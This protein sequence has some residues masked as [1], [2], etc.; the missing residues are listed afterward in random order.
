[1]LR[2]RRAPG[3]RRCSGR[4][5]L[6]AGAVTAAAALLASCA[7][8]TP[9]Q[10][11]VPFRG[12]LP[13]T[14]PGAAHAVGLPVSGRTRATLDVLT[15]TTTLTI[16]TASFGPGG[17]LLLVSTPAGQPAAQLSVTDRGAGPGDA[18]VDLRADNASAVTVTLSA[19]VGWLLELDGGTTRTDVD[20][21]GGYLTGIAFNAGSTV[22]RVALPRPLGTVPV[23]MTGGA[24]QFLLSLPAGVPARVTAGGGAGEVSLDGRSHTG[25]GGGSVFA[26][27]GW[28]AGGTGFDIDATAG[29]SSITVTR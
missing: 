12:P 7:T 29:A 18:L 17:S 10:L 26:T 16:G 1:V 4:R 20:L 11:G 15:G 25:V 8:A 27:P 21:R 22:I 2:F 23:R 19:D 14:A 13:G 9:H 28:T 24:S 6:A 5:S 3:R